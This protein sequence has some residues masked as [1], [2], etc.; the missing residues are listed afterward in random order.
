MRAG[1]MHVRLSLMAGS[2]T[3]G[4]AVAGRRTRPLLGESERR[5]LVVKFELAHRRDSAV[6]GLHHDEP[7]PGVLLTLLNVFSQVNAAS[8]DRPTNGR[9]GGR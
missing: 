1:A 5:F 2:H 8:S 7:R 9:G 6:A 4:P 3:N